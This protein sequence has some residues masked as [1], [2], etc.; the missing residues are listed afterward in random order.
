M[1]VFN[2]HDQFGDLFVEYNV[3]LP[4]EV[5]PQMRRSMCYPLILY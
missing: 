1:P 5:S 3:V 2:R 4:T